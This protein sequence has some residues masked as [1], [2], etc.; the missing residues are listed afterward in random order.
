MKWNLQRWKQILIRW[1][2]V[3]PHSSTCCS[4]VMCRRGL[5]MDSRTRDMDL[6]F[7]FHTFVRLSKSSAHI[8]QNEI[9]CVVLLS[10]Q[11]PFVILEAKITPLR[12]VCTFYHTC[13]PLTTTRDPGQGTFVAPLPPHVSCHLSTSCSSGI[14][15]WIMSLVTSQVHFFFYSAPF[16][17]TDSLEITPLRELSNTP[18][19]IMFIRAF[20]FFA[21]KSRLL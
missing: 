8:T 15:F 7:K 4:D 1:S 12:D 18:I 16:F 14:H 5:M 11:Q 6:F 17:S 20:F 21:S 19:N 9:H 13:R 2:V 3:S 10:A